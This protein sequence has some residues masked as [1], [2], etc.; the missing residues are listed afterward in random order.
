M[1]TLSFGAF[2]ANSRTD[3]GGGARAILRL[4]PRDA[5]PSRLLFW[6]FLPLL[7]MLLTSRVAAQATVTEN[8]NK[9]IAAF[10]RNFA[11]YVAWPDGVFADVRSPW[12]VCIL[13]R[14]PFG[15]LLDDTLVGRTEQGRPFEIYRAETL[16]RLPVCQILY[17]EFDDAAKRRSALTALRGQPVLTVGDAHQFLSEGGII[18][19]QVGERVTMS[20]N[21]DRARAD[22]LQ[23]QTKML[24]VSYATLENGILHT[25]KK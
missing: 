10:L 15:E 12:R 2:I 24:E 17:I 3:A 8:P 25:R 5:E 7:S 20:I 21:L 18:E 1:I 19:L 22:S 4:L 23:V 6:V 11:H 9:V 14:D 16:D 13:G